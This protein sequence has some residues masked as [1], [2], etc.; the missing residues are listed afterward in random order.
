VWLHL[1]DPS[2]FVMLLNAGQR[3]LNVH[4]TRLQAEDGGRV[5]RLF[6]W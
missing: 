3:A 4:L 2:M 6:Q 1:A 5:T